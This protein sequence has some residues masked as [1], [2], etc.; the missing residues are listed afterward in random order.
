MDAFIA[1]LNPML[2]LFICMA[3]GY[4]LTKSGVM[5]KG[6]AAVLSKAVT[7]IFAPSLS[8]ITMARSFTLESLGRGSALFIIGLIVGVVS[9]L[10]SIPSVW[11]WRAKKSFEAFLCTGLRSVIWDILATL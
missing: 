11:R 1:L 10:I 3:I 6:G 5:P 2:M 8:F 4:A 7:W 9:T